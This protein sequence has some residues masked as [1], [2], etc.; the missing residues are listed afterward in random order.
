MNM[1]QL[2]RMNHDFL[3]VIESQMTRMLLVMNKMWNLILLYLVCLAQ[4]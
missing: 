1:N 2:I 3:L 4:T